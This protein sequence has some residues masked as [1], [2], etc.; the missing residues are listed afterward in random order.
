M[1]TLSV[2]GQRITLIQKLVSTFQTQTPRWMI[3]KLIPAWRTSKGASSPCTPILLLTCTSL[4]NSPLPALYCSHLG[5][6]DH[7][8]SSALYCYTSWSFW[9]Q[10]LTCLVLLHILASKSKS[11]FIEYFIVSLSW[12]LKFGVLYFHCVSYQSH[13]LLKVRYT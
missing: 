11:L 12:S 9:S 5:V 2:P 1:P 10:G 8:A 6:F 4:D 13:S 3:S 7:F